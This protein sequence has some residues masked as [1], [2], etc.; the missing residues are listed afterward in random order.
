MWTA[1]PMIISSTPVNPRPTGRYEDAIREHIDGSYLR[2]YLS[3]KHKWTDS[4]W[5]CV[6]WYSHERHLKVLQGACL[7]QRLKFIHDWQPANSQKLKFAKSDDASTPKN[8]SSRSPTMPRS[9]S[10]HVECCRIRVF[11]MAEGV[12]LCLLISSKLV[13][14]V[15]RVYN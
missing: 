12:G 15:L 1:S 13:S 6:D 8:S 3:V 2:H 4:T 5:A 9:G 14:N 11:T 10:A 7:F